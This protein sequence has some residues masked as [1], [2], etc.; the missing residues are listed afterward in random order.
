MLYK[1]AWMNRLYKQMAL[2]RKKDLPAAVGGDFNAHSRRYR[3]PQAFLWMRDALFQPEPRQKYR[4]L[5][6]LG[7]IDAFR[8]LHPDL[9]GQFTFWN[10]FRQAFVH[11]RNSG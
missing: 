5:L 7:Y 3:L 11:N 2:W 9:T 4:E 6:K 8:S 1:L 10:Y